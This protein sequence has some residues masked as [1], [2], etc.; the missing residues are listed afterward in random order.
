MT[1]INLIDP[2]HL[3]QVHAVAEYKE[4]TQFLHIVKKR[5]EKNHPMDDLPDRYTLNGGHCKFFFNK[6]LYLYKR[7][8]MLY[9][10][11][12]NRNITIDKT[13]YK[14]HRQRFKEAYDDYLWCDYSPTKEDYKIAIARILERIYLK[15]N[16]Y[17]DKDRFISKINYY[18]DL[19][20]FTPYFPRNTSF[21]IAS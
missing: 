12:I 6:G 3:T 8:E 13:R 2:D 11:L 15:P 7:Y 9:N 19:N 21:A 18:G 1:R 5:V 10:N 17:K 16:M 14:A 20:E 4:I